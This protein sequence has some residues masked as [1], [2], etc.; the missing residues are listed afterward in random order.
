M[1][2]KKIAHSNRNAKKTRTSTTRTSTKPPSPP[3]TEADKAKLTQ[4]RHVL[5]FTIAEFESLADLV[6]N[7]APRANVGLGAAGFDQVVYR[8][9]DV[10]YSTFGDGHA[11]TEEMVDAD[12]F[13]D[14]IQKAACDERIY[15]RVVYK[16]GRVRDGAVLALE[17]GTIERV[18]SDS[19][20][21]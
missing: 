19:E 7:S 14:V 4:L 13:V 16:L 20:A 17:A 10:V 11:V 3:L 2:T 18:T 5:E 8:L 1:S 21:A 9:N 15:R 6:E 12:H